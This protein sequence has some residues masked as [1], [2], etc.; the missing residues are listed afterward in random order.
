M[1]R[2]DDAGRFEYESLR[3]PR[4]ATKKE[5]VDPKEELNEYAADGWRL[6]E[7]VEYVGG[8]TKFLILERP[9]E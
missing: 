4:G 2:N 5:S 8:G 3:V 9:V 1:S 6:V 7:T